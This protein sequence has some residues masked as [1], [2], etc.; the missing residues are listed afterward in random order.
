M[1]NDDLQKRLGT[2]KARIPETLA[3]D[4]HGFNR[5]W[6]QLRQRL[7]SAS[8][9]NGLVSQT[10]RLEKNV[11]ASAKTRG[12]RQARHPVPVYPQMKLPIL[13]RREAIIEAIA[14]HPVVVVCGETGS[15]KTTQLPK[16]CL[17]A[18]RGAEGFIGCTQPR[19]IAAVTV[20]HRIAE[21]FSSPLGEIVGY[22]I[23]FQDRIRPHSYIKIMT[24]G[25][26]LAETQGDR[27]LNSYDTIIVD[28]AHE[29]SLN[30]DFTLGILR[31]LVKR[32]KDLKAH[33]HLGH[34][35]HRKVFEGLRQCARDRGVGP[36]V[37]G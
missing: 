4:R 37:P 34:H 18:G 15:G 22:K 12:R 7:G 1:T 16:F 9:I 19:R 35:R 13:E 30:I 6:R 36:H 5:R 10:V 28:E 2:I 25:I 21:E 32:R 33:H 24:D 23:R 17:A 29:R 14:T 26:L 3:R 20:A 27:F 8:S 11:A 31:N